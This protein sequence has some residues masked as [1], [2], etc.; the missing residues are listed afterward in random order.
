MKALER[1]GI[2]PEKIVNFPFWVEI[3]PR[4]TNI[5]SNGT[6][7]RFC[8]IGRL[9]RRKGMDTAIRALA[10]AGPVDA[11]LDIVGTGPQRHALEVLARN[12]GVSQRVKFLGAKSAAEMNEYLSNEP[13]CLIHAA[14]QHDPFP[15]VV[16]EAMA[17]GLAV[18]ASSCSGSAVDRL[19]EGKSGFIV[20][21]EAP[22]QVLADHIR[23]LTM[24]PDLL[25]SMRCCARARAE[26]WPVERGVQT[27]LA[28]ALGADNQGRAVGTAS[29]ECPSHAAVEMR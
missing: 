26:E 15:V 5:N 19:E 16:L 9:V 17:H 28:L 18:L 23:R 13:H 14:P 6:T 24:S 11:T 10:S 1:M 21:A 20:P 2:P 3:P 29:C 27:L 12:L 7:V 8:C 25:Y 22:P 4:S